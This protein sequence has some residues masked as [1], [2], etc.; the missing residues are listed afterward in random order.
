MAASGVSLE[1]SSV[2]FCSFL[3]VSGE[4]FEFVW[5]SVVNFLIFLVI[6]GGFF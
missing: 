2:D 1:P 4:F 6:S 3:V 5:W